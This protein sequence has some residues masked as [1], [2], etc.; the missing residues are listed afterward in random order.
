MDLQSQSN[1]QTIAQLGALY[2][3]DHQNRIDHP[4]TGPIHNSTNEPQ[5]P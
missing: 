2:A 5:R 3:N 4:G 1:L